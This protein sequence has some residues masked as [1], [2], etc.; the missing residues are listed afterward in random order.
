M[1]TTEW[2]T[3]GLFRIREFRFCRGSPGNLAHARAEKDDREAKVWIFR[4]SE[5]D[6]VSWTPDRLRSRSP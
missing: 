2:L 5:V 6:P 3:L 1:T 4:R